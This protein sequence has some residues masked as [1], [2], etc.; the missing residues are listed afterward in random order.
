[1]DGQFERINA[2]IL[3]AGTNAQ[4]VSLVG[5]VVSN[6]GN[7]HATVEAADGGLVKV[8]NVDP[9]FNYVQGT[10]VEIMGSPIGEDLIQVSVDCSS[11]HF[12]AP[13]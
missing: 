8:E 6:D 7:G 2:A 11:P 12:F 3:K 4:V 1:M 13:G 9:S 5:R 10:I